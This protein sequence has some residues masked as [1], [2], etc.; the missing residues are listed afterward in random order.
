MIGEDGRRR[1]FKLK[2]LPLPGWHPALAAAFA[3][4]TGPHGNLRTTGSAATRFWSF[5][6][7][8]MCLERFPEPPRTP[9]ELTVA[10]LKRYWL[11]RRAAMSVRS[12]HH[13][14]WAV[15]NL[16]AQMPEGSVA[17]DVLAWLY[18][19]FAIGSVPAVPGYSDREFTAIMVAARSEV[20]AIRDRLKR[21]QRL[22]TRYEQEPDSLSSEDRELAAVLADIATAGVVP[23]M[24]H[25]QL[26][27][28]SHPMMRLARHLFVTDLDLG[29]LITLA[30][31][32]SGRNCETIKD[33][34]V[35]HDVLEDKAVR[36][37][38]V[39]RRRGPSRMFETVHWEIGSPNQQL[40]RPGG[41]YLLLEQMMRRGRLFSGTT[42]LWSV[43]NPRQGHCG[44]FDEALHIKEWH[45]QRWKQRHQFLDDN[46]QPLQITLPRLKKTVDVRNTRAA[47]GHLPSSIRSNTMPVL[48][49]NYLRGDPSV[50][51]WA[52]QVITAA[53]SDAESEAY[54]CQARVL[55]G[56]ATPQQAAAQLQLTDTAA[57]DLL[58][59][60]LDTAFAACADID[61]SPLSE[62]RRCSASFMM[63]FG[64]QNAL[65]THDHIPK[66]KALLDWLIDQRDKT[67]RDLWWHQYGLTWLVITE[68]I[69]P[70]FT[71][72]EWDQ[73]QP[74]EGLPALLALLDGPQEPR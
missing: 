70:K 39:K 55:A 57:A 72:A 44:P 47:G 37:E 2:T 34:T 52:G 21:G 20:A 56:P 49:T 54:V 6:R 40:Q 13:E 61:H 16:I 29:P 14:L 15:R 35:T 51:D 68:H 65:V 18:R 31:G 53:L 22:L 32:L 41:Y 36:V 45:M 19:R 42:S 60:Q 25:P 67:D 27:W 71:P 10:H 73:A 11:E 28:D 62:G 69:R 48:F 17:D 8:L 30:V 58:A 23:V 7:F 64:C 50:Q 26:A 66:L 59:G 9:T 12:V 74:A 5:K 63:C 43:W 4:C 24:G 3:R 33:L 46:G 1:T 38:L